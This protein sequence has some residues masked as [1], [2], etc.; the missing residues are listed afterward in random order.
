MLTK[1]KIAKAQTVAGGYLA[2]LILAV[3]VH[4]DP[5]ADALAVLRAAPTTA[6]SQA[7]Q[8]DAWKVAAAAEIDELPRVLAAMKEAGP[9]GQ[10]WLRTA[11]DAI[12]ERQSAR[13]EGISPELLETFALD[14]KQAPRAR[15]VAFEWLVKI[16]PASRARLLSK[17]VDDTS[18][19]LRH[20]AIAQLIA[21]AETSSDASKQK[22][23]YER[24]FQSARD[25]GQ[26]EQIAKAL[27]DLGESPDQASQMGYVTHWRIIGPFDNTGLTGFDTVFPPEE[28]VALAGEYNGKT[29]SVRWKPHVTSDETGKVDLNQVVVD[30]K[31]VIAYALAEVASP[32][33]QA[34]DVR[35]GSKNAPKVW[36]N[37]VLVG[38]YEVYHA[39]FALDQY[40][41]PIKL[42][43]GA[44]QILVKSCQ[45]EKQYGW[46]KEWD[47]RLRLTDKLGGAADFVQ[48]PVSVTGNQPDE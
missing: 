33:E 4:G 39:G 11:A 34:I 9:L 41:M 46:E 42:R 1:F 22:Q 18:L 31:E 35:V 36:I 24:A 7:A 14:R 16:D 26:I 30:D 3:A 44:N 38:A 2:T 43:R 29:G 13:P 20:D 6:G 10:N 5:L 25:V 48:T 45:N 23:I 21:A 17:M 12:A 28:K 47:F 15:R 32:R 19:E 8:A 37:G 40:V 27:R